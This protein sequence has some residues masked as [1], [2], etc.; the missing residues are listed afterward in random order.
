[1]FP[2]E[3]EECQ[4]GEAASMAES[5]RVVQWLLHLT[6]RAL[7]PCHGCCYPDPDA[8]RPCFDL[9]CG[10]A[11]RDPRN[12]G[13]LLKRCVCPAIAIAAGPTGGY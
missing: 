11:P 4:V 3:V 8:S 5:M 6:A 12:D 10:R 13:A 9:A 2:E 1:M 7:P